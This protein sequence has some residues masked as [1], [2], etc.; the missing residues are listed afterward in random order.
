M[1]VL[2]IGIFPLIFSPTLLKFVP[3][4]QLLKSI[5]IIFSL[6]ATLLPGYING[7]YFLTFLLISI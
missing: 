6:I 3:T 5:L 1:S 7:I 4:F 2:E